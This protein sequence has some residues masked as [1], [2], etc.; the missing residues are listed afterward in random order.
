MLSYTWQD[1]LEI[2]RLLGKLGL[3]VNFVPE[4]ATVEQFEQLGEAAVTAPLCPT[5]TD[6]IS[7]GLKQEFG[8]PFFLYPPPTG[9]RNTDEW[10]RKIGKYT[11]KEEEVEALIE[12]E[13]KIWSP[14]LEAIKDEFKKIEGEQ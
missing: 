13:H 9:I 2:K 12:E 8:V 14:K 10:L 11:G 6:Y 7:R 5:Y 1:R 4:F 3:R